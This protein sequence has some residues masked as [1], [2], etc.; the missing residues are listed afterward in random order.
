M[1]TSCHKFCDKKDGEIIPCDEHQVG[2]MVFRFLLALYNSFKSPVLMFLGIP[3]MM[4]SDMTGKTRT[5]VREL[6]L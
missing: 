5:I 4:H 3:M 1:V 6:D 2:L